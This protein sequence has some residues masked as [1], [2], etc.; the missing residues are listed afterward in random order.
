[1]RHFL[2]SRRL[3]TAV[4]VDEVGAPVVG[5]AIRLVIGALGEGIAVSM[6]E[7]GTPGTYAATAMLVDAGTVHYRVE[8]VGGPV[9]DQGKLFVLDARP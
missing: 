3:F 4:V 6:P 1:M 8:Q 7:T 9:L 2:N 5:A